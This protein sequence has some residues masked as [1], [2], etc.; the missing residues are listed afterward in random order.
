MALTSLRG[1][2]Y[3]SIWQ[4]VRAHCELAARVDFV[5][6]ILSEGHPDSVAEA[7]HQKRA[8]ADG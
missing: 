7:V 5:L 4:D 3:D 6:R 1:L 2:A 8:D